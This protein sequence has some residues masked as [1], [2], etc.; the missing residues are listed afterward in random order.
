MIE[1]SFPV[2]VSTVE[3][4]VEFLD[5]ASASSYRGALISLTS[6]ALRPG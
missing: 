1:R 3:V 5:C 6:G 4:H 2:V